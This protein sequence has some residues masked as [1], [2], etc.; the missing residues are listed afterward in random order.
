MAN[1]PN[2]LEVIKQAERDKKAI[3]HFNIS[4]LEGLWAIFRAAKDLNT[5]VIIGLSEGERD[6]I[7]IKQAR[8]LV[9]S[10]KA[11]FDYPIYLNADHTYSFER[12]REVVD[13][14]FDGV[15][16]DGS[17][18]S[19]EDNIRETKK[20][21]EYAKSVN[22]QMV[23]EGEMGFIGKSSKILDTLPVGAAVTDES[24]T[25]LEEAERFVKETGV[26]LFSPAVG[27][28]HGMLRG[29][30]NPK[31]NTDRIRE[32]REVAG[33][34]LVLHGGSGISD[35]DFTEAIKSGISV[36]HINTELRLAYRDALRHAIQENPDEIAPYKLLKESLS[37]MKKVAERRLKLFW[38]LIS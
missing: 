22:P 12:V 37:E 25:K 27:N 10:L 28:I 32:I 20:C 14:G 33:V 2:M 5:P 18:L 30:G 26:D 1:I 15:I 35:E 24:L 8:A 13:A 34:P 36:V 31:L 7:G 29:G 21:V 23:V 19:L 17:E 9:D 16:F 11:E 4:N 38:G 6:F 3:G